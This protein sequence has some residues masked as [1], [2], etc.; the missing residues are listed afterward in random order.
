[1]DNIRFDGLAAQHPARF[2]GNSDGSNSPLFVAAPYEGAVAIVADTDQDPQ[3]AIAISA[4][5]AGAVKMKLADN[6]TLTVIVPIGVTILPLA[7]K[8]VVSTGTTATVT[9]A[10][11][12]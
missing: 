9:C 3:H 11:L 2:R 1:M 10:N 7:V 5:V 6:S 4:T 8:T 12:K